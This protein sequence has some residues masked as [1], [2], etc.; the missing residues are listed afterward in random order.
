VRGRCIT[1]DAGALHHNGLLLEASVRLLIQ[2]RALSTADLLE[3]TGM[4]LELEAV[5]SG[6]D[7]IAQVAGRVQAAG[8]LYQEQERAGANGIGQ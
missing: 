6:A 8:V 5:T 3:T 7:G 2:Y 1:A 4:R